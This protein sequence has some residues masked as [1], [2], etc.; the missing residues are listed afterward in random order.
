MNDY[1]KFSNMIRELGIPAF[2]NNPN[3][4]LNEPKTVVIQNNT[5]GTKVKFNFTVSGKFESVTFL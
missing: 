5:Q 4:E 1:E 3:E 2:F